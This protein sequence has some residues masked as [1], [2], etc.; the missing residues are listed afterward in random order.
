MEAKLLRKSHRKEKALGTEE[1]NSPAPGEHLL[2]SQLFTRAR[3]NRGLVFFLFFAT[4][5]NT[6]EFQHKSKDDDQKPEQKW[7]HCF[8][9]VFLESF[10]VYLVSA[11]VDGD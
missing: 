10:H 1:K 4:I 8:E 3:G 6:G 11:L 2:I 5:F 9:E 7:N